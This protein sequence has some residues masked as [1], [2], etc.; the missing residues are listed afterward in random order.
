MCGNLR[1]PHFGQVTK[2]GTEKLIAAFR[3]LV[4]ALACFFLGSGVT[5]IVY[6]LQL[7]VDN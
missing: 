3:V 4:L 1:L 6:S 7:T 5:V 2:L